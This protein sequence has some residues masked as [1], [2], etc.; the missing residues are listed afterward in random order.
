MSIT[1]RSARP[2]DADALAAIYRPYVTDTAITFETVPPDGDEFRR[3]MAEVQETFPYLVAEEDGELLGY[4]YAHPFHPRAA[5]GWDAEPSIYLRQDVRGRGLGKQLYTE[6]ARRLTAQGV[7]S[8]C[9]LVADPEQED[10]HLTHNSLRFHTAMGFT[11]IGRYPKCSY[12]FGRWYSMVWM[13][14]DLA[15]RRDPQPPL[16]PPER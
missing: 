2:E 6:L 4:C 7:V 3:R 11:L 12:K 9:A 13:A 5:Y 1:I 10:E 15:P 8:L 16:L 14:K